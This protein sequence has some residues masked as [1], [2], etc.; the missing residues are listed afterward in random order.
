MNEKLVTTEDFNKYEEVRQSGKFNM[1]SPEA[2][3]ATGLSRKKYLAIRRQYNYCLNR[4][5]K[6]PDTHILLWYC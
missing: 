1:L 2:R 6:Y 4:L 5:K 3:E